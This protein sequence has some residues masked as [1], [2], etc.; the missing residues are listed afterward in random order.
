MSEPE[1]QMNIAFEIDIDWLFEQLIEYLKKKMVTI[2]FYIK[3]QK[4]D[5]EWQRHF[6]FLIFRVFLVIYREF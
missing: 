6:F 2:D 5:M 1:G 4:L 3:Q